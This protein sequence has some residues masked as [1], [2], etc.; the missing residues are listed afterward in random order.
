MEFMPR[1]GFEWKVS[2]VSL[3]EKQ[4]KIPDKVRS[5]GISVETYTYE[6]H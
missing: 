6:A 3:E 2:D 4:Q 1:I 5:R